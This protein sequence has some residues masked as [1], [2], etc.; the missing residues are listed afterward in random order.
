[1]GVKNAF[2]S[3][4]LASS[5]KFSDE[6]VAQTINLL[7]EHAV[8]HNAS[9]IH[10]E[11]HERFAQ[12]RYRIDN[13][14]RGT[15]KLPLGALPAVIAQ[16]KDLCELSSTDNHVPQEGR[17]AT[18]VGEEQFEI[19]VYTMPVI[20]GEKVVLHIFQRLSKPPTLTALGFWGDG[21]Q[22]LQQAISST[23]G[24]IIVATPRRNGKTTTMHSILRL[25]NTPAVSIA[26]V[27]DALEYRLNGVN[28]TV[29]NPR[30]GIKIYDGLQAALNQDPNIIMLSNLQDKQTA[31]AVIQAATG[32]HLVIAGMHA[33]N[34]LQATASL[35]AMATEPFLFAHALKLVISQ[36][37]VR[38]LCPRC[39][40]FYAPGREEIRSIEKTFGLTSAANKQRLYQLEQQAIREGMGSDTP[41][42]TA[43]GIINLW[44][45]EE[46]GCEACNHT[47]YQGSIAITEILNAQDS[48]LQNSLLSPITAD[49]IRKMALQG[50]FIPMELDGLIKALRGQTTVTEI[51]RV[52]SL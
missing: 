17:Y 15:H 1:M 43:R 12:V 35:Q 19:Q 26:T 24:L 40:H 27:E 8:T 10:I 34:T 25:L 50:N 32:G 30:Q 20:G 41:T 2:L 37:L 5:D 28:Q 48:D 7:V 31:E 33:D 11:P 18:L 23:H 45:S 9:D 29:I 46:E 47:G 22:A 6:Q 44:R 14:L 38:Q 36:R 13:V 51:L 42:T 49:N 3:R 21:L 39:C 16:L 52:L 4:L